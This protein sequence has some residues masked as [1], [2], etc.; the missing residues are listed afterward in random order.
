MSTGVISVVAKQAIWKRRVFGP[1]LP[2]TQNRV[3][4]CSYRPPEIASVP[5]QK[6]LRFGERRY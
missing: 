2:S 4:W 6:L 3:L 5:T 1:V